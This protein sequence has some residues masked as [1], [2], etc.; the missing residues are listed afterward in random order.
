MMAS[1]LEFLVSK[2]PPWLGHSEKIKTFPKFAFRTEFFKKRLSQSFTP[3]VFIYVQRSIWGYFE[4]FSLWN[5]EMVGV[6]I[7]KVVFKS[8]LIF[9][10]C[11]CLIDQIF[12]N[13]FTPTDSCPTINL[14]VLWFIF[15]IKW[16]NGGCNNFKSCFQELFD[17]FDPVTVWLVKFFLTILPP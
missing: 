1:F 16:R 2:W 11:D 13:Y 4:L 17:F 10:S 3:V 5:G 12:F 6:T 9:W 8:F 15:I 7:L 14:S